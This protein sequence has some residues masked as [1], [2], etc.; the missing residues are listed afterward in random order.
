MRENVVEAAGCFLPLAE[1]SLAER[2][3]G[4]R[5]RAALGLTE[6]TDAVVV[7]VSEET[8]AICIAREGK[9][10]RPIEDETRLVKMLLAVT[11]PPRDPRAIRNDLVTHL[12]ARLAPAGRQRDDREQK[13]STASGAIIRKN[14][15]LKVLSLLLAIVGW[16]YFRFASNPV[17]AARFDQQ[18]SRSDHGGESAG[19]I[20]RALYRQRS[21]RHGRRAS[22]ASRRSNPTKSK[23]CSIFRTRTAGVYN[24]PVQLVAPN[25]VDAEPQPRIGNADGREDRRASLPGRHVITAGK[26]NVGSS[27]EFSVTPATVTVRGPTRTARAGRSRARGRA[28]CAAVQPALDAMVRPVPVNAHGQEIG[29]VRGR[30]Q[31]RAGAGDI[32]SPEREPDNETVSRLFGTDGVRGVANADLTPELAFRGRPRRRDRARAYERP[33][34]PDH[35]RARHA[36]SG[37]MLEAAIVAGITSVGRDVVSLGIVADAGGRDASPLRT[38]AAAGV[39][40]S[41]SHNPIADNGIKFFGP[42]GF[43]LSD[44]SKTRSKR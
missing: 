27:S 32:S 44:E 31:P 38:G 25:V 30:T 5:H 26:R 24:V 33:A 17:I 20:H 2:R 15:G 28:A 42:D 10:S 7:V 11:R 43:K 16:A 8:G 9:L 18:I 14:F 29:G 19:R 37:T 6:Q 21:G 35:R 13:R 12:R 4:T 41:A 23:P 3:V 34:S 36:L 22:A 39:M 1:Q 40:I